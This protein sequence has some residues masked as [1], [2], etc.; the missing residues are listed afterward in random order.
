M[1][2]FLTLPRKTSNRN[3][4]LKDLLD[5]LPRISEKSRP[6]YLNLKVVDNQD[7]DDFY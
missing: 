5:M 4:K 1:E 7:E 2:V 3:E 6:Y